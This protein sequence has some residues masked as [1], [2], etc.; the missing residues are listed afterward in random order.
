MNI[1]EN[2]IVIILIAAL[3]FSA[4]IL[5]GLYPYRPNTIYSWIGLYLISLP[6]VILFE[7]I[8]VLVLDNKFI[9]K[10]GKFS[11]IFYGVVVLSIIMFLASILLSSVEPYLSE[12]GT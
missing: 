6:V 7:Y 1:I 10:M 9:N 11:R 4:I 3:F 5:A 12:W 8:G 2:K